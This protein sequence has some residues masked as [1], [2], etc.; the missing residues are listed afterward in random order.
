MLDRFWVNDEGKDS[1]VVVLNQFSCGITL[2][3]NIQYLLWV[4][5]NCIYFLVCESMDFFILRL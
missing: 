4:L 1:V 5:S 2:L 3:C